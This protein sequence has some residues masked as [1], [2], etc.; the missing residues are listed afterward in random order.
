MWLTL[1]LLIFSWLHFAHGFR[2][3]NEGK[4]LKSSKVQKEGII[5]HIFF[6][7]ILP[8]QAEKE[9]QFFPKRAHY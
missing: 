8:C 5:I 9:C 3:P 2:F 7:N 1:Q 6:F 4:E